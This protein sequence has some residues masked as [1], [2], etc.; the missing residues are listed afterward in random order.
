MPLRIYSAGQLNQLVQLQARAEGRNALN[1][2][3]G[4]WVDEGQPIFA[5]L[6]YLRGQERLAAGA[7]QQTLDAIF[8]VRFR[9]SITPDKRLVHKGQ[10]YDIIA[11]VP[12]QG[13]EFLEISA[14]NGVRDGR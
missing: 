7:L 4:A 1:E 13:G 10:P 11:A 14:V 3:V 5:A 6:E 12:I 8:V 9:T 2:R